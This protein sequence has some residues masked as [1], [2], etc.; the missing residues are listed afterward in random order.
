MYG[1]VRYGTVRYGT[2][3]YGTVRYGSVVR[4]L[5]LSVTL[6]GFR[7]KSTKSRESYNTESFAPLLGLK[8]EKY[9]W[10]SLLK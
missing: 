7:K 9:L 3:R 4:T 8:G 10:P 2:V 6:N 1:T 5:E